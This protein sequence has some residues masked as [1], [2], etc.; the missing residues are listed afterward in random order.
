MMAYFEPI[1]GDVIR[2]HR[3]EHNL[4]QAELAEKIEL[5]TRQ[6][7]SIEKGKSY[8]KFETL[9]RI[10]HV[11]NIP[12]NLVF[13]SE[14]THDDSAINGLTTLLCACHPEDQKIIFAT[15][16]TLAHQLRAARAAASKT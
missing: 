4:T 7:M 6:L 14:A 10:V 3:K 12:P 9:C 8:P 11:L 2:K 1:L 15:V 16:Q 5:T 13:Y